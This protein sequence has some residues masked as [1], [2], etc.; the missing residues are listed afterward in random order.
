MLSGVAV[1][2][3][4]NYAL[5]GKLTDLTVSQYLADCRITLC[6]ALVSLCSGTTL[7]FL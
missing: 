3:N 5:N 7:K 4:E 2:V 1:N 6:F